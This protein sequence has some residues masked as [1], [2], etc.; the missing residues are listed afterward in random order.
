MKET[1]EITYQAAFEEL[2]EIVQSM[3]GFKISMDEVNQR[4]NRAYYLIDYCRAKLKYVEE[5]T[6]V[7]ESKSDD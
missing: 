3:K 4:V 2:E 5:A 6:V 7:P 1:E